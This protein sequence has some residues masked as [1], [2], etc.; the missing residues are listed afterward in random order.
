MSYDHTGTRIAFNYN[1]NPFGC[2]AGSTLEMDNVKLPSTG[3]Y[4][5]LIKDCSDTNTGDY[6]LSAQCFGV[7]TRPRP[8]ARSLQLALRPPVKCYRLGPGRETSGSHYSRLH[9]DGKGVIVV[10]RDYWRLQWLRLRRGRISATTNGNEASR[11]GTLSIAGKRPQSRRPVHRPTCPN[12]QRGFAS[13]DARQPVAVSYSRIDMYRHELAPLYDQRL[14]LG[15]LAI[16][17]SGLGERA[18]HDAG[19]RQP[20]VTDGRWAV[21]G[22]YCGDL[23]QGGTSHADFHRHSQYPPGWQP[24]A[25]RKH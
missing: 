22:H 24:G 21:S 12:P 11:S 18:G 14:R 17:Q 4:T 5:V 8:A 23:E 10:P 1:G 20:S 25:I 16:G 15:E 2:S 6:S 3:T 19:E 7:C 13:M 9:V